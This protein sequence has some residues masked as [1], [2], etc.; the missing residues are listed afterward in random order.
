MLQSEVSVEDDTGYIS[1]M[2]LNDR[3][4]RKPTF[5]CFGIESSD[6]N[7]LP[8]ARVTEDYDI[9]IAHLVHSLC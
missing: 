9:I 2:A 6:V 8:T 4:T 1:C 5:R 7:C 3:W